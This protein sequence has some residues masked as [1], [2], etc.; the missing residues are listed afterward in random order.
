MTVDTQHTVHHRE[1]DKVTQDAQNTTN[2]QQA[3]N[4][5]TVTAPSTHY[6]TQNNKSTC[7][8]ISQAARGT[9]ASLHQ[10]NNFNHVLLGRSQCKSLHLSAE[11]LKSLN[12]WN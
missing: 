11:A 10:L 12:V 7:A 5:H 1:H 4:K 3:D 8:L 6:T 2:S 9:T